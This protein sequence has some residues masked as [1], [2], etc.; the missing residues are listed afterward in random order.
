MIITSGKWQVYT[1]KNELKYHSEH[2]I[3]HFYEIIDEDYLG[4]SNPF[5]MFERAFVLTGFIIRRMIE[6]KL[7][8]E[9]TM[10]KS[11]S[12]KTFN[13]GELNQ[14]E[15]QWVGM[16]GARGYGKI[17]FCNP[18][19]INLN[20]KSF[21]NEIIHCSQLSFIQK[22]EFVTD[23]ILI[24]SDHHADK[25]LIQLTIEEYASIVK[26]IIDDQITIQGDG[27]HPDT[28]DVFTIRE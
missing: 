15:K 2:A 11:L 23:G 12:L 25:R 1:W 8:T 26:I 10:L 24:A 5:D 3:Q 6:K 19:T 13:F 18:S 9:K 14:Y 28:G 17:D 7:V 4:D 27:Y 20:L 16:S 21:G 22:H